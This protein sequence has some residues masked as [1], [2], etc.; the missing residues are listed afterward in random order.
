MIFGK[1][2]YTS[3]ITLLAPFGLLALLVV[4]PILLPEYPRYMMSE[5][6]VWGLLALGFDIIFGWTGLLNFGMSS[7]FGMGS[8]GFMLSIVKLGWGFWPSLFIGILTSMVFSILVG[9]LVTRFKSH[10]FVVFTIIISMVLF[11]LAMNLRSFTGGDEG[12]TISS[13]P[14]ISFGVLKISLDRTLA[15][16]YVIFVIAGVTFFLVRQIFQAPLGLAIVAVK[17]NEE[18]AKIVGYNTTFLKL[19]SFTLS[20]T[21]AGLAGVL[22]V[23]LNGSTNAEVFFWILSGKAVLWTVVGGLGTLWGPFV[24]AAILVYAEDLLSTWLVNIYPILVG[25]ILIIVIL[26]VPKGVIG[27]FQARRQAKGA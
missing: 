14:P 1:K 9:L 4:L 19:V 27:Y 17:E 23:I 12:Y 8:F 25:L 15:K 20:G 3:L 22:Y 6:L 11:Y 16:Y 26:L 24:G 10:Y 7:F 21:V 13:I 18:R 5:V 2:G